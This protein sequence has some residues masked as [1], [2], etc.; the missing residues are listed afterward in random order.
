MVAYATTSGRYS[1]SVKMAP[2]GNKSSEDSRMR[3][4][5]RSLREQ[6]WLELGPA[7]GLVEIRV[8]HHAA[9]PSGN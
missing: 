1:L 8:V 5:Y 6:L 3:Y 9:M 2:V 4:I 7:R